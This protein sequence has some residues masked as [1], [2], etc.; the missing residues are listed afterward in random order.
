[1]N[2]QI[3]QIVPCFKSVTEYGSDGTT[4]LPAITFAYQ[5]VLRNF[6]NGENWLNI[7]NVNNDDNYKAIH[8]TEIGY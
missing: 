5:S 6:A 1:M 7:D 4:F 2:I 3:L 8:Y